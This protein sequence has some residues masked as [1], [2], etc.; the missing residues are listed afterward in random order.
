MIF[1]DDNTISSQPM[2]TLHFRARRGE[3][4]GPAIEL[5]V[6]GKCGERIAVADPVT[7][8]VLTEEQEVTV[9][10]P[11]LQMDRD[12]GQRLMD[13]LWNIGI[14]PTEG[15]GSAGQMAA[16]QE[17]LKDLRALVF[18]DEA[19]A[20]RHHVSTVEETMKCRIAPL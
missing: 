7:L 13:E 15:S 8:R 19:T 14:R 18:R 16:V 1:A 11:T 10:S 2:N 5:M 4:F 6:W 3:Y 17:H 9:N 20:V 12:S